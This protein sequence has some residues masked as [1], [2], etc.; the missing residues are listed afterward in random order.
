MLDDGDRLLTL[1][2]VAVTLFVV[3]GLV[4]VVVAGLSGPSTEIREAPD[5]DWSLERLNDSHVRIT[6]QGGE[7]VP[8]TDLVVTADGVRRRVSWRGV[9]SD[10][11]TGVVR[12]DRGV[13]VQLYW[14]SDAG[15]RVKLRSWD[16]V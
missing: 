2:G 10:G 9:V 8:A 4:G 16:D 5:S 14:T 1:F 11:D 7:A 15:E 12:A 13:L 6:H 3:V